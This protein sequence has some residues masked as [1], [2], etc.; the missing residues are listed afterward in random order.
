MLK[1]ATHQ[2]IDS[3]EMKTIVALI[4]TTILFPPVFTAAE[5]KTPAQEKHA[6]AASQVTPLLNEVQ[7]RIAFQVW[8]YDSCTVQGKYTIPVPGAGEGVLRL[9]GSTWKC[10]VTESPA[11]EDGSIIVQ[12]TFRLD[13]GSMASSAVAVT[14]DFAGWST[15]NYVMIPAIVYNGNRY[16]MLPGGYMPTYPAD[17][18]FNS[19][20]PLTFSNSPRLALNTGEQ[21]RIELS[22][23][24][25]S[26][27]AMTFFSPAKKRGFVLLTDP[28]TNL[29]NSGMIIEENRDRTRSSFS[30]TAPVVRK[31]IPGFGG[32]FRSN[33][34]AP[35]WKAG[36]EVAIHLL[37]R[38]FHVSDIPS[39]L[40]TVADMRKALTGENHPRNLTPMSAILDFTTFQT[41]H[42]RWNDTYGY[43]PEVPWDGFG[44]T[45][46]LQIGWVGGMMNT[47]PMAYQNDSLHLAKV[48]KTFD[49]VVNA[50]RGKSGYFYG[51]FGSDTVQA[52]LK[53]EIPKEMADK[54]PNVRVAMVRKNADVLFWLIKQ[55]MLLKEQGN[56]SFIKPSWEKAAKDLAHAFVNTWN[57]Y[58]EVGQY[59]DPATGEIVIYNSTAAAIVPAGL[60]LA[61]RYF[62]KPHFLQAAKEIADFYYNRDLL[63]RGFT[64]GGC[65]DIS[66]DA[67]SETS[68]G[69]LES[70]M[71][72]YWA[73][74]D[75]HWL[76]KAKVAAA[77]LSTWVISYDFSFPPESDLGKLNFRSAGAVWAS[78]QNKHAAPGICTSSGDYLFKLYRATGERRYAD[79]IR[80]IQHAHTEQVETPGRPT[81]T[82]GT[83][84]QWSGDERVNYYGCS[85][86]RIQISDS[87]GKKEGVGTFPKKTSNGWT[88]LN[89]MLMA[90]E[91]P[92]IYLC[93]DTD[94]L[95]VFDHVEARVLKRTREGVTLEIRNPT[96]FN[97]RVSIFAETSADSRRP[98][99]YMSFLH[100]RRAN[101]PAGETSIVT[102]SPGNPGRIH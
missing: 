45:K 24:S 47:Y 1:N 65:G 56:G 51:I 80:D 15:K 86:E 3:S 13:K 7:G 10:V 20:T 49:F 21:S 11:S 55:F 78:V 92:G 82:E 77:L 68:G 50:M 99:G 54:H 32:F 90:M 81:I 60:A 94:E 16:R 100:W 91:I 64:S 39:F 9:P 31:E 69:F 41:D 40:V 6:S 102:I 59:V 34:S 48:G 4:V 30:V 66:Q 42:Y 52:E 70:M 8:Q 27:P 36:D 29:G 19:K 35:D 89:G 79:L 58:G 2:T 85:V 57:R 71:A 88:E 96:R 28:R 95:Y 61:S 43:V 84:G 26:T 76:E 14:L 101:V 22:T 33:D 38:T 67:D 72:L 97:A 93:L 75:T 17:M 53:R 87:E 18:Y 74:G 23:S 25:A 44:Y 83:R 12:A 73:T 46:V 37:V 63:Q 62:S 5:P 98:L